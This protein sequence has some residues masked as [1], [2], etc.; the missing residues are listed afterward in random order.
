MVNNDFAL[1]RTFVA[2]F[3][4]LSHLF[5]FLRIN[6]FNLL[7]QSK[8]LY[9]VQG[10]CMKATK[11]HKFLQMLTVQITAVDSQLLNFSFPSH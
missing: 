1:H 8:L 6:L 5:A 3:F 7:F 2:P 4:S 11:K 10:L 9:F